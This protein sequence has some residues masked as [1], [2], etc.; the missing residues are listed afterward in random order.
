MQLLPGGGAPRRRFR[1]HAREAGRVIDAGAALVTRDLRIWAQGTR[2]IDRAAGGVGRDD[3]I[4]RDAFLDP[5]LD[6]LKKTK[7]VTY[8]KLEIHLELAML[9]KRG[10]YPAMQV[11]LSPEVQ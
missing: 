2:A 11:L 10:P 5:L 1:K 4:W 7:I 3:P 8:F 9:N 6:I